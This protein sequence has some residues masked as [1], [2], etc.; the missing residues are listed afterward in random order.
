MLGA[1]NVTIGDRGV[2]TVMDPKERMILSHGPLPGKRFKTERCMVWHE[3]TSQIT[4]INEI[5]VKQN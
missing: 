2:N 3:T 1:L 5:K 4:E